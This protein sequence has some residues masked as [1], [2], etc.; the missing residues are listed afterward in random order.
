VEWFERTSWR[1]A[2]L[3]KMGSLGP[4]FACV[5]AAAATMFAGET[6]A[7]SL[8]G[9]EPGGNCPADLSG[10]GHVNGADLGM[11]LSAW[12]ASGPGGPGDLDGSSTVDGADLGLLLSAWGSC[13]LAACPGEGDCFE[14]DDTPGCDDEACCA[15]VCAIDDF[16]CEVEWDSVCVTEAFDLCGA[17]GDPEAGDCCA[18]HD[19]PGCDHTECCQEVCVEDPFCCTAT[20]DIN[21]AEMA[22]VMCAF[23]P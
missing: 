16:C 19:S 10:D 13:P 20:W 11:L 2:A 9:D 7:A 14:S 8:A 5:V 18:I 1:M 22:S 12:N 21:C 4:V 17:C 6:L 23:C 15:A 3:R